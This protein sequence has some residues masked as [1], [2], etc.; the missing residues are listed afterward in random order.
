MKT[1]GQCFFAEVL[2][3]DMTKRTCY[4]VPP[5]MIL[6]PGPK[7]G[8]VGLSAQQP[9]VSVGRRSCGLFQ[10]KTAMQLAEEVRPEV[11]ETKQ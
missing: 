3:Q 10:E 9:I 7:Q 8:M 5:V 6:M 4:G 2:K 11:A 1:C